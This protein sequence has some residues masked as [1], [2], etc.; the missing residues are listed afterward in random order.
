MLTL[1]Y[2]GLIL[3]L[4]VLLL[5]TALS[6]LGGDPCVFVTGDLEVSLLVVV[7]LAGCIVS[8]RVMRS[9]V[10]VPSFF[11]NSSLSPVLL[12]R[13]RL[14]SVADVLKGIRSK[15]FTQS[16]WNTLVRYWEGVCRHGPCGPIS[17][18][19]PW[20]NWLPP[21][22]HGFYRWVFDA[23]DVLNGFFRQVVV[24]RRDE[25]IRRWKGWLSE[26]LSSRPYIWLRLDYVPPPPFLVVKDSQTQSSRVVV[27]PHLIDAEFRKAWMPYFCRLVILRFLQIVF[28]ISSVT[29]CLS[30][31]SWIFLVSRVEIYKK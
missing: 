18:L 23:L 14:K 4:E 19:H 24:S 12:F 11:V 31:I 16:R 8:L 22:L 21:D 3:L 17:S 10:T 20:D 2:F 15:A 9:V 1:V 25:G 29:F 6:F 7:A 30:K 26:D 28:L 13:R 27:E 5:V